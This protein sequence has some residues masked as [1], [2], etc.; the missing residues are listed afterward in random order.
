VILKAQL[1][2]DVIKDKDKLYDAIRLLEKELESKIEEQ[3]YSLSLGQ[4]PVMEIEGKI[5]VN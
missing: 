1:T 5:E 4:D 2:L 3:E